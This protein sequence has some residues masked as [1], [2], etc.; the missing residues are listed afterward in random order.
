M[1]TG[2]DGWSASL[3]VGTLDPALFCIDPRPEA[4][5]A[6]FQDTLRRRDGAALVEIVSPRGL[7]MSIGGGHSIFLEPDEITG[8]FDDALPRNWGNNGY[9]GI[10]FIGSL[11]EDVT[12]SLIDDFSS[13][14][15]TMACNDNQDGLSNRSVL[16][17]LQI[18]GYDITDFYSVMRPGQA[19]DWR[20]WG[21]A[22]E[23]WEDQ[24]RLM[25]LSGYGWTP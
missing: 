3:L 8:F 14:N 10:D 16:Y 19:L 20:A 7:Y 13:Q 6:S 15:L 23:Y 17:A 12:P 22:I 1:K 9:S 24:P 5:I 4:L 18:A 2:A 25:G 11:A 21:L